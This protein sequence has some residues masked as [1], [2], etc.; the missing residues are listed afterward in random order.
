ML[1]PVFLTV[2][3]PYPETLRGS[4]WVW[5]SHRYVIPLPHLQLQ[6]MVLF[7]NFF[8]IGTQPLLWLALAL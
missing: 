8:A 4:E 3:F 1:R 7:G 6:E 5:E 2:Q